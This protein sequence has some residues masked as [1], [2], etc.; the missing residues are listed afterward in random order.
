V[1]LRTT[2]FGDAAHLSIRKARA[3][4]V[5]HLTASAIHDIITDCSIPGIFLR[6]GLWKFEVVAR[7]GDERCLFAVELTQWLEGKLNE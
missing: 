6:T 3:A 2:A 5:E 4:Y 1:P 7:L